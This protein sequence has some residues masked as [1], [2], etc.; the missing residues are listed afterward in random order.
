MEKMVWE[1]RNNKDVIR[2][3]SKNKCVTRKGNVS[4]PELDNQ[5]AVSV[6]E[7]ARLQHYH[8]HDPDYMHWNG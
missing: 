6:Q 5:D 4:W 8:K 3:I 7:Q 2:K 1:W